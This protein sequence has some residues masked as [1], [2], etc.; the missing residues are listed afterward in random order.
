MHI[1]TFKSVASLNK[2]LIV[3]SRYKINL[4]NQVLY[5]FFKLQILKKKSFLKINIKYI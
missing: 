5:Y 1:K 2:K 4:I 3:Q